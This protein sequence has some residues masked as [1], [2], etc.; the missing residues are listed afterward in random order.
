M[1][2]GEGMS[3]VFGKGNGENAIFH[4]SFKRDV[5]RK[6]AFLCVLKIVSGEKVFQI[7]LC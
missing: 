3:P 1:W 7:M 2:L 6:I 5:K 4:F